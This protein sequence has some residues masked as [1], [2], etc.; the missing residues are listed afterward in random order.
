MV[1]LVVS[2]GLLSAPGGR[3]GDGCGRV[4][5]HGRRGA[6]SLFGGLHWQ[7]YSLQTYNPTPLQHQS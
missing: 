2:S 7:N 4:G 1:L 3:H 6:L 5:R